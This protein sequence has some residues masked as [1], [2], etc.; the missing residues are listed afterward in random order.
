MPIPYCVS[1]EQ[2]EQNSRSAPAA[3]FVEAVQEI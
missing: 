3:L 1:P 2:V